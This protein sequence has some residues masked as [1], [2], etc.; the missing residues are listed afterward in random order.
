MSLKIFAGVAKG[1][2]LATPRN[3]K[4]RPTTV[5]LRRK[6][7]DSIQDM[8]DKTFIDL[9]CG[10][11]AMGLEALSRGVKHL[12]M[13]DTHIKLADQNTKK[14]VDQ[15]KLKTSHEVQKS[16][17]IRW[18]NSHLEYL[19][20]EKPILFFDP[21]YE[22]KDLYKS[23]MELPLNEISS[24]SIVEGCEQKTMRI[25]EFEKIFGPADKSFRQGTS[26]FLLYRFDVR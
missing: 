7:F 8:S 14:L 23:F 5:Q 11:G 25:A 1:F 24:I 18:I 13:L 3:L 10:T 9:C 6:L 2:S 26:Y 19:T 20:Q 22:K 4:I 21:P 17:C 12:I 15:Y 16:D